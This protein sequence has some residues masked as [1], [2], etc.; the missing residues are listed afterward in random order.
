MWRFK[1]RRL[2]VRAVCL[3]IT[4]VAALGAGSMGHASDLG[5][6]GSTRLARAEAIQERRARASAPENVFESVHIKLKRTVHDK[7]WAELLAE[8]ADHLLT[9]GCAADPVLCKSAAFRAL[10]EAL[11]TAKQMPLKE[12]I[13]ILNL[14]VNRAIRFTEDAALYRRADHWATFKETITRG[15]GDCEDYALTKMW[16]FRAA[17]I[18]PDAIHLVLSKDTRRKVDHAIL[19][20][21]IGNENLVLDSLKDEVASDRA[22]SQ[23]QPVVSLSP[24]GVWM[25]GIRTP[26]RRVIASNAP[27]DRILEATADQETTASISENR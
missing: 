22:L 13:E 15:R 20:V 21:R 27:S 25:H 2:A 18:P 7:R 14:A 19:I 24:E 26:S 3:G 1:T 12:R 5:S 8:N 23:Y 17:G 6:S 16:L 10:S 11:K 9:G 4:A